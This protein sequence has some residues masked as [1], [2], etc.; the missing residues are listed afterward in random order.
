MSLVIKVPEKNL[1]RAGSIYKFSC[2][3]SH[4]KSAR[5]ERSFVFFRRKNRCRSGILRQSFLRIARRSRGNRIIEAG[6]VEAPPDRRCHVAI[7]HFF[8]GRFALPRSTLERRIGDGERRG[9]SAEIVLALLRRITM[10]ISLAGESHRRQRVPSR[11]FW[12]RWL[13]SK[14]S[15]PDHM[16]VPE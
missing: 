15:F 3:I 14:P 4:T 2:G 5:S 12:P 11:A 10:Y 6:S 8:E 13:P 7:K 16:S 1:L 9:A